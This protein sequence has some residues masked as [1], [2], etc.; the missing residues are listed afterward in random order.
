LEL[1]V[2]LELGS[3]KL[4]VQVGGWQLDLGSSLVHC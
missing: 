1:E 4:E 2:E 3:W